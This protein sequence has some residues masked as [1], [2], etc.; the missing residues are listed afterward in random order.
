MTKFT[1]TEKTSV[2]EKATLNSIKNNDADR[3]PTTMHDV[4]QSY[5]IRQGTQ[6]SE[7]MGNTEQLPQDTARA[8]IGDPQNPEFKSIK[9]ENLARAAGVQE[10]KTC[11]NCGEPT[12]Y[13][14]CTKCRDEL[15]QE[16]ESDGSDEPFDGTCTYCGAQSYLRTCSPC[17]MMME[18]QDHDTDNTPEST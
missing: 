13:A 9:F 17:K 12:T 10:A 18:Y 7:K 11:Y 1:Q 15:D 6:Y 4:V 5:G 3:D 16:Q 14:V 8:E 2:Q